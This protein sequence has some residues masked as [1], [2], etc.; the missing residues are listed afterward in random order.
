ME[1]ETDREKRWRGSF[2]ARKIRKKGPM[3]FRRPDLPQSL[4]SLSIIF[5]T[6]FPI[7]DFRFLLAK[8]L[9][10]NFVPDEASILVPECQN[11]RL[12]SKLSHLATVLI[13]V[14]LH[15]STQS[16]AVELLP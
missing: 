9:S 8:L 1:G 13:S 3:A 5:S 2:S 7:S 6:V 16:F 15:P 12:L 4:R 11:F 14:Y 10:C